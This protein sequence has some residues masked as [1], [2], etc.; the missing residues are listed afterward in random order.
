MSRGDSGIAEV[1][2]ISFRVSDG[3]KEPRLERSH[4]RPQTRRGLRI[5]QPGAARNSE[6]SSA[7]HVRNIKS[8]AHRMSKGG[9]RAEYSNLTFNPGC[10][11]RHDLVMDER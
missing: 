11:E 5:A 9:T 8:M 7:V 3:V 1:C 10:I 4:H 6:H 2:D